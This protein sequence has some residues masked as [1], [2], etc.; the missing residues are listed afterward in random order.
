MKPIAIAVGVIGL[1]IGG[2]WLTQ[3][4]QNAPVVVEN[5]VP[6]VSATSTPKTPLESFQ[7]ADKALLEERQRLIGEI[8]ALQA[9]VDEIDKARGEYWKDQANIKRYIRSVFPEEPNTAVSV[10]ELESELLMVQ[11]KAKYT[12][13]QPELGIYKGQREKS[14]CIFQ[15][16][17]PVWR[18]VIE[19]NDLSDYRTN[20][21]SCVKMARIIYDDA[22]GNFSDWTT[23]NEHLA[24][25]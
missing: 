7:A 5:P 1:L 9:K 6:Q 3:E 18:S 17:E 21:E 23:Y 11:S 24:M 12:F 16:H 13:S 15:I 20:V 8:D 22:G 25:R 14:F 2:I 4:L 19:K 10:A